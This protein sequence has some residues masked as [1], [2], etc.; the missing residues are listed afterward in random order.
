MTGRVLGALLQGMIGT[1]L[2]MVLAVMFFV[3]VRGL[4]PADAVLDQ[5]IPRVLLFVDI[6]IVTWVV[7]LIVG[8]VRRR[9]L[10]WGI[11]GSLLAAVIGAAMNLVWIIILSALN[12]G[13]DAAAIALGVQAGVFFLVAVAIT[14]PLVL[15]VILRRPERTGAG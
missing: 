2:T 5:A 4:S 15:R 14:A 11:R 1:I 12:G 9:G 8:A 6:G 13:V 10:G 7:L 3:L